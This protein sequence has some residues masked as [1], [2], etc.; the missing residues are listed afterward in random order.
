MAEETTIQEVGLGTVAKYRLNATTSGINLRG[1]VSWVFSVTGAE[2][3]VDIS[4]HDA[5]PPIYNEDTDS[6]TVFID[7][8]RTGTGVL[9]G[10]VR[11][12]IRDTDYVNPSLD[13]SD[14][15]INI[16]PEVSLA[17]DVLKV[18]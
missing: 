4:S 14:A 5:N 2:G 12:E 18:S 11:M 3:T 10:R 17:F 1:A 16:R 8:L 15:N 6:Y 9:K 7:T 13:A